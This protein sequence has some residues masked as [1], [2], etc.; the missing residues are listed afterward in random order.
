[1]TADHN[2]APEAA[3]PPEIEDVLALSPLQQGLF[4]LARLA[5]DGI[6]LY[7]MQFVVDIGGPLDTALLRRSV[8]ALLQR[9]ASL[10]AAF[11]DRDLP[12]PVQII[13]TRA[14][15]PWSE[16]ICDAAEFDDLAAADRRNNFDLERGPALRVTLVTLPNRQRM[17]LTAH[18]ILMDGWAVAVFFRELIAVYDAGGSTAALPPTRPYRDYIGWLAA[19]DA[20]TAT[21]A[22]T[23]HL[24]PLSGPLMLAEANSA[25]GE[26]V[27]RRNRFALTGPET[28]RLSRWSRGHGL[29]LGTAVQFAWA[30]VLSRLTDRRDL[31]FGTTISGRPDG[32]PGV[33]TMI[34]LFINT[35][36]V[37]IVLDDTETVVEHCL[38]AQREQAAMRDHGYLSLSAIQRAAGHGALFDVLFVFE[39]APIGA[40]T[41]PIVTTSGTRFLPVAME[42]L[43]HYPLSVVAYPES[44]VLAVML[45]AVAE[46]FPH[47]PIAD[48]GHRILSVLRQ[49]PDAGDRSPDTL[50]VLLPTERLA[51]PTDIVPDAG[52][53]SHPAPVG[54]NPVASQSGSIAS[55]V[56]SS[57]SPAGV[58]PDVGSPW[59]PARV[60]VDAVAGEAGS[61]ASAVADSASSPVVVSD[62][63]SPSD[64]AQV[65]VDVV[66]S[67]AGSIA[68]AAADSAPPAGGTADA[69]WMTESSEL[70]RESGRDIERPVSARASVPEGARGRTTDPWESGNVVQLFVRQAERT[71][72]APALSTGTEQFT[73][74]ELADASGR[75]AAE[76]IACGIGPESVVALALPRS[77]RAI[78]AI[79]AVLRAGG[80]YAPVDIS[81]PA[82]R[83]ASILR[84]SAPDLALTV[85]DHLPLL[86]DAAA[87]EPVSRLVLDDPATEQ[88]I[89][90]HTPANVRAVHELSR[91]YLIF[92]SGST[93]EPKGVMGTH[94]ALASYF[95]DHRDRVYRPARARLGRALRIAH[96]WSLSFDASWQPLVG[97]FDGHELRLFDETEMRDAHGLVAGIEAHRIDMIDTT[98]SMFTQLSA[99]GLVDGD[100]LTVLALGGEAIG[101]AMWQQ[102]RSL[103]DTAV[104]NC[105]GPTE[106]TVEAVVAT[107]NSCA[108]QAITSVQPVIGRAV[109]R[110]TGYVLDSRL[111]LAPVGA[112]GELYLS[113]AQVARG[114][115][116]RAA[117][118]ADRFVADPFGSGARMYRTGDLVRR[119]PSGDFAYLG[120][121]DDQVKIR[122]YRI[123]IGEIE[124]ALLGLPEVREAA[125]VVVTRSGTP[126]L[127][128]F[129]VDSASTEA[130]E[131]STSIPVRPAA[132]TVASAPVDIAADAQADGVAGVPADV[133]A[134][135]RADGVAG[136]LTDI[137]AGAGAFVPADIA[138]DAQAGAPV[139]SSVGVRADVVASAPVDIAAD[140]IAGVPADSSVGAQAGVMPGARADAVAGAGIGTDRNTDAEDSSVADTPISADRSALRARLA[141]RLPAYMIPARILSVPA[142]PVTGN[143]KLDVR[144]L[145][146]IASSAPATGSGTAPRTET[147][148]ALCAAFTEALGGRELGIDD[149]FLALGVD[150]IVAIGLVNKARQAGVTVSPA[151]VLQTGTVRELAA[152]VDTAADRRQRSVGVAEYG[153][154]PPTPIM[155]WAAEFGG[156]RRLTLSTLVTLPPEL[157][158]TALATILQAVL[159]GHDMMRA[160]IDADG[161]VITR[162]PGSVRA[163]DLI[164]DITVTG[165]FGAV[166]AAQSRAAID[167]ID[168]ACGNLVRAARF[169]REAGDILLLSV[170]HLAIDPVSWQIVLGDLAEAW[171]QLETA[172][173]QPDPIPVLPPEDTTYRQWA[174]LLADRAAAP[175]VQ[176]QRE[177]WAAQLAGEDPPLG[178]RLPDP[179]RDT[180]ASYRIIPAFTSAADTR[181]LLDGLRDAGT[182][183]PGFLLAALTLTVATWKAE[184]GQPDS[185][186]ILVAL[187][188]HGREDALVGA[189]TA[190]T[191]GWFTSVYPLRLGAARICAPD[192][193]PGAA[194]RLLETV[195]AQLRSVPNKG[196]DYG[197]LRYG[198]G[199]AR[200][201]ADP[202]VLFDHLGRLDLAAGSDVLPPWSPVPD[203]ALHERLPIAPEPDMPLRYALDLITAVHPGPDGS[204][205]VALWRWSDT[206][207][208]PAD[209][210]RLLVIWQQAVATLTEVVA[211]VRA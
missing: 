171:R 117:H 195:A 66:A 12:S 184:R 18:H 73:Y 146:E 168:P 29:T 88:R 131:N 125:V 86:A 45:E 189:D 169:R 107:V 161:Q 206:L 137:S 54:V 187:E 139:D 147:E 148:R 103:P 129:V 166:L 165:D 158:A 23:E 175:E 182:D 102:L 100:H 208:D 97:L 36:P 13:P 1:M 75:L 128:G 143:G 51:P 113:G 37:R 211:P 157:P 162:E 44:D 58:V 98:P 152:A 74:A 20:T 72:D 32:L 202:Q 4:S 6:D 154:V 94:A 11:W 123:E 8:E 67:D 99:A 110:M 108:G 132:D 52:S 109:D 127:V 21:A 78:V 5:T 91:A 82:T 183:L 14:E 150:S 87:G 96:A 119:T 24:R 39:N 179:R 185:D 181:R 30:I 33:E 200:Q 142:L 46:A 15:L 149:E 135:A 118:T 111:R 28:D 47:F 25:V 92:T 63:S 196:L 207:F 84:Q 153:A 199:G 138:A 34:G 95:A 76:L 193:G 59:H 144:A 55:A 205:L 133:S 69:A 156:F 197:L 159:D 192:A 35:V 40:A 70:G 173:A 115:A 164:T 178:R 17:I 114:Y 105:Y 48:I 53:P 50:D 64:P 7:T 140:A 112:V 172:A 83:I 177:F 80:A 57:A 104:Y 203:L 126:A 145:T 141:D 60:G 120:R 210:D 180:W 81:A 151:L 85:E 163:A 38:R 56:I 106:T 62:V 176:A 101:P 3:A 201:A 209:L 27:P 170:H 61:I 191:V 174:R 19:R 9:H 160:R 134:S 124:S 2:A 186:G 68:A 65:G 121:A 136:A 198:A 89:A 90:A 10:R 16:I 155:A 71:P 49:L 22:W 41:D 43:V 31:V 167:T 130:D 79:L 77:A 116:G 122:G 188:G 93:G 26:A 42:S 194:A 190:R 204:Q